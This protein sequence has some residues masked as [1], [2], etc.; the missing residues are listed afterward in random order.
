MILEQLE[1]IIN[2]VERFAFFRANRERIFIEF[3]QRQLANKRD[4]RTNLELWLSKGV[5]NAGEV[6]E[7]LR[8]SASML[9]QVRSGTR[10]LSSENTQLLKLLTK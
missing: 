9:S 5:A 10:C 7:V 6:A 4:V 2:P 3:R 8:L 1:A